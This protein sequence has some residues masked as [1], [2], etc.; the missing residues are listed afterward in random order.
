MGLYNSLLLKKQFAISTSIIEV[1]N[2]LA[3]CRQEEFEIKKIGQHEY[4]FISNL[5]FGT[6]VSKYGSSAE[7]IKVYT[8]LF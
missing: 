4:K 2:K 3:L 6:L 8:L 5:S 7:G 1:E